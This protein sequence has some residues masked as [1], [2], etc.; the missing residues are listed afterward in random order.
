M[1]SNTNLKGLSTINNDISE[2]KTALNTLLNNN[3]TPVL[4]SN[5]TLSRLNNL[6]SQTQQQIQIKNNSLQTQAQNSIT[7]I[8]NDFVNEIQKTFTSINFDNVFNVIEKVVSWVEN[9]YNTILQYANY[10]V[11]II[12]NISKSDFKL[13]LALTVCQ[14]IIN[15]IEEPHLISSINYI[16]SK[17][18]PHSNISNVS[19]NKKKSKNKS[20]KSIFN[21][22]M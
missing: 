11:D 17:L 8:I 4:T 12:R 16:V 22:L 3:N 19:N 15:F 10:T 6:I 1:S 5:P 13:Q 2:I 14:Q 7:N 20:I 21:S 9:N 18:F